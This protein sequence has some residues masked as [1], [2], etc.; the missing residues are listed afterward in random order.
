M[1][2]RDSSTCPLMIR[3]IWLIHVFSN[4]TDWPCLRFQKGSNY[5]R[6]NRSAGL[7][8]KHLWL[9]ASLSG[10]VQCRLDLQ[11]RNWWV[12]SYCETKVKTGFPPELQAWRFPACEDGEKSN[13]MRAKPSAGKMSGRFVEICERWVSGPPSSERLRDWNTDWRRGWE[14]GEWT[15][16]V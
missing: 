13:G 7:P 5:T 15:E 14:R 6:K 8:S 1:C 11:Q 12:N 2:H 4:T 16:L 9:M 10:I 3:F